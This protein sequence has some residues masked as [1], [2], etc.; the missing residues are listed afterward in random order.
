MKIDSIRFKINIAIFIPCIIIAVIFGGILYL[1]EIKRHESREKSVNL[2]LDSVFQQKK[3]DIANE[4]FA[5][6]K[7]ALKASLYGILKVD[8]V[9]GVS[10]YT[11]NGTLYRTAGKTYFPSVKKAE[12]KALD[13]SLDFVR[14]FHRNG[15]V[16][17]YSRVIKVIGRKI[18]YIKIKYDYS[19]L[20]RETRLS[21]AIFATLLATVLLF[22]S[23]ILSFLLSRFVIHPVMR[24]R[25]AMNKVQ[26]GELGKPVTLRSRDEIGDMAAAF[27]DM[28]S[29]LWRKQNALKKAEEKYRDI[30]ENAPQGIFQA[31]PSGR[32]IIANQAFDRILG[33]D[34]PGGPAEEYAELVKGLKT[35]PEKVAEFEHRIKEDGIVGNFEFRTHRGRGDA[36]DVSMDVQAVR[37]DDGKVIYYEGVLEDV[38]QKKRAEELK[39]AKEAAEAANQAKGEFLANMSHE[40]RTPMNGVV[41]MTELLLTTELSAPQ[42]D[43]AEAIGDS[44][45][46]LLTVLNDILDF[47]KIQAGKL[48]LEFVRFNYRE[49]VE[50]TGQLLAGQCRDKGLEILVRYPPNAPYQILGDPTRIRQILTNL[51]SNAIK[52]TVRGHVLIEVS[53]EEQGGDRC[54]LLTRVSDTG[55]GIP[56]KRQ[57]D[58][59]DKFA[60]ADGSTTREFGGTG[61]GLTISKQLVEMMGG[62]IGVES[63]E[64]KGST[65]FFRL[66]LPCLEDS[67]PDLE[68]IPD[69]SHAPILVV[70]DNR[71]N[72]LILTE[73][74]K[75][76]NIPCE[77]APSAARALDLLRRASRE[78]RPFGIAL[79]DYFMPEMNGG[80]LAQAIKA[81]EEIR[82]M[83]LILLSSGASPEDVEPS[84][85][86]HFAASLMK[87]VRFCRLRRL[88]SESWENVTPGAPAAPGAAPGERATAPRVSAKVLLVEDNHMNQRVAMGVLSRFGCEVDLAENGRVAVA[89]F[90]EKSYDMIFMDANMPIMD[91]FEATRRIR[92]MEREIRSNEPHPRD[93]DEAANPATGIPIIAMTAL[94]MEG[95]RERCLNA[96]MDDYISKPVRSKAILD[97]LLRH[98]SAGGPDGRFPGPTMVDA[99]EGGADPG[100]SALDVAQLLDISDRDEET[101]GELIVEFMK[102]APVYLDELENAIRTG[103]QEGIHKEAHRLKGLAANAGGT[104]LVALTQDIEK[105]ARQGNLA[106]GDVDFTLIDNGLQRLTRALKETDWKALCGV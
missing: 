104:E 81:D 88:L 80:E 73:Y 57:R 16:G 38:T 49:V 37:D 92:E 33:G 8:G 72:R 19:E 23:G 85:R 29:D 53:Y 77:A 10:V 39:I 68:R 87:P 20:N 61:L 67:A 76:L 94:A 5:E 2:L 14:E 83:T 44:A 70:D 28:S 86:S 89:L 7:S 74:L 58:I 93:P 99:T 102:D 30:F 41:G 4:M 78:G 103:D 97:V 47:S 50:R 46:A 11:P 75:S 62:A 54:A 100:D 98:F 25:E 27:N 106:P 43:Y 35:D 63:E 45:N 40:I 1:L 9:I 96:G 18:G 59:F 6:Q 24:L 13:R 31:T 52:F 22:I 42:R 34:S 71:I 95:D 64:E 21:I 90:R 82:D 79:L 26:D 56:E 60:Q 91:G 36:I 66:E 55:I 15:Q 69:F 101:I 105:G 51:A 3:E 48:T 32:I 84:L 65:F 12:R 17:V